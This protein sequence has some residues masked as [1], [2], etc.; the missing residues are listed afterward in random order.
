MEL[1]VL[2]RL[3]LAIVF[4]GLIGWDR[5]RKGR[6]AGLRTHMLVGLA[7]ALLVGLGEVYVARH[8]EATIDPLRV[9]EAVV[10][11]VS[12]LGAGTVFVSK[13]RG[14]QGLT[15]AASIWAV[16][17]VGVAVGLGEYIIATGTTVLA[18]IVLIAATGLEQHPEHEAHS[19]KDGD[20]E[21]EPQVST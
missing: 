19:E 6:P 8:P 7:S 21:A 9:L 12:F 18:L 1:T 20:R 10:T 17:A 3:V 15:T 4:A 14:V 11:G 2:G 16:S 5:E 13:G